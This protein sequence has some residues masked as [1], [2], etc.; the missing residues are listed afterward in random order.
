MV[1]TPSEPNGA[2]AASGKKNE[3]NEKAIPKNVL[4]WLKERAVPDGVLTLALAAISALSIL[5]YLGG[6]TIWLPGASPIPIPTIPEASFWFLVT[7]MPMC[8]C[9]VIGRLIR[10]G[11]TAAKNSAHRLSSFL[12]DWRRP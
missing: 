4:E 5:P 6:W 2:E 10:P 3:D 7:A 9:L 11:A 12:N 8:W 1:D